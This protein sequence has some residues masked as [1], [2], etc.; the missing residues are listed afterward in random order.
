LS[1]VKHTAKS[2]F[3]I[4]GTRDKTI[5][6]VLHKGVVVDRLISW[7]AYSVVLLAVAYFATHS[8]GM[9]SVIAALLASAAL[10][11]ST[12]MLSLLRVP[13]ILTALLSAF[14]MVLLTAFASAA[15]GSVAIAFS[16]ASVFAILVVGVAAVFSLPLP[17]VKFHQA[18]LSYFAQTFAII[19]VVLY[20]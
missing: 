13:V 10:C 7:Q 9:G 4:E 11:G 8:M 5:Q 6:V 18:F 19:G 14:V 1:A 15:S 3:D 20:W 12:L 16:V 2:E 17:K